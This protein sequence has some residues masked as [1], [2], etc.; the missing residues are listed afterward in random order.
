MCL[1]CVLGTTPSIRG[2]NEFWWV[3]G[4][5]R[6][7][8]RN[9]PRPGPPI[10]QRPCVLTVALIGSPLLQCCSSLMDL[11]DLARFPHLRH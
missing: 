8:S 2:V 3:A 4:M 6:L 5:V 11:S 1:S 7:A 9:L 10:V